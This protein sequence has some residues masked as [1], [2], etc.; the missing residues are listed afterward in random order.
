MRR[1]SCCDR[2]QGP[3]CAEIAICKVGINNLAGWRDRPRPD[4]AIPDQRRFTRPA[5]LA[6]R[7]IS[8]TAMI[9]SRTIRPNAVA[10]LLIT[11][12]KLILLEWTIRARSLT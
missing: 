12:L 1:L 8:I 3:L 10:K 11:K 9:G 6:R 4:F 7:S 2:H 5:V